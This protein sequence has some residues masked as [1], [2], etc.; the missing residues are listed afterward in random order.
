MLQQHESPNQGG[1][2]NAN[3]DVP[4]SCVIWAPIYWEPILLS[5]ERITAIIVAVGLEGQIAVYRC[6]RDDVI[7]LLF[8]ENFSHATAMLTW[9]KAS[10]ERHLENA[11]SFS[12][13]EPPV[14]GFHIGEEHEAFTDSIHDLPTQV[15]TL[16]SSFSSVETV[17]PYLATTA[18][19]FSLD[20]WRGAIKHQVVTRLPRL[21]ENFSRQL[22]LIDGARKPCIDYVGTKVAANFGRLGTKNLSRSVKDSKSQI[23]DLAMYK[24]RMDYFKDED[25]KLLL[26]TPASSSQSESRNDRLLTEAFLEIEAECKQFG[27]TTRTYSAPQD[28]AE[29]IIRTELAA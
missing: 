27:L 21:K 12:D 8:K 2:S 13:W 20:R 19:E 28:A 18:I 4:T 23:L 26:W 11:G 22:I 29:E 7:R 25:Y 17:E 5:G 15:T 24:E 1:A 16:C 14:S 6:I 3:Q 9:V 10:I